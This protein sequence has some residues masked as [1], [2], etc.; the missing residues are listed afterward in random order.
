M[1]SPTLL[2]KPFETPTLCANFAWPISR[3]PRNS[4]RNV[5]RQETIEVDG[6]GYECYVVEETMVASAM[7]MREKMKAVCWYAHGIGIVRQYSYDKKGK[8]TGTQEL[9]SVKNN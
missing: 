3:Y 4:A 8:L 5:L 9:I 1:L 7:M 2:A 6:K